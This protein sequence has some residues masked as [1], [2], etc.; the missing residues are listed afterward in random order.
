VALEIRLL[1]KLFKIFHNLTIR[2]LG[3]SAAD[4]SNSVLC[5]LK[6]N[7]EAKT[8]KSKMKSALNL[9]QT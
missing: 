7:M 1:Q 6:A 5:L 9:F 3:K 4:K 2:L 8:K